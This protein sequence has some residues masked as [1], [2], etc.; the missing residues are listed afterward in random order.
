MPAASWRA[1]CGVVLLVSLC[2]CSDGARRGAEMLRRDPLAAAR[3]NEQGLTLLKA[4]R[5]AE[6]ASALRK[7]LEADHFHGPAYNNLGIVLLRQGDYWSAGWNLRHAVQLMPK[8]AAPRANLGVL[9]EK[10]GQWTA[11]EEHLREALKL[12]PGDVEI[13]GHLARLHGRQDRCTPETLTWLQT[14]STQDSN[15]AWQRW[16]RQQLLT[17]EHVEPQHRR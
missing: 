8:A 13:I 4:G 11:S 17:A 7:S 2:G 6:A 14:V 5:L 1:A 15:P 3:F 12:A 10:A 9:F 16:A